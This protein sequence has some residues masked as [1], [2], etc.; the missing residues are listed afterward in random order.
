M[1]PALLD[2]LTMAALL[3]LSPE[4]GLPWAAFFSK[5][6]NAYEETEGT[7]AHM[8]TA[9]GRGEAPSTVGNMDTSTGGHRP[10]SSLPGSSS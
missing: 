1:E 10:S 4:P 5:G 9:Q 7:G 8:D 3:Q 2:M 6:R